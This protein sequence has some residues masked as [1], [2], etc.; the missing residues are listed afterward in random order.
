M[1]PGDH[2]QYRA[3][4]RPGAAPGWTRSTRPLSSCEPHFFRSQNDKYND[5]YNDVYRA[6][7][8]V[9]TIDRRRKSNAACSHCNRAGRVCNSGCRRM[10]FQPLPGCA[11]DMPQEIRDHPPPGATACLQ[12]MWRRQ[13]APCVQFVRLLLDGLRLNQAY[14]RLGPSFLRAGPRPRLDLG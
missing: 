1:C 6:R 8:D 13:F 4:A 12:R 11:R 2:S 14:C 7:G 10:R 5:K 3:T 9:W